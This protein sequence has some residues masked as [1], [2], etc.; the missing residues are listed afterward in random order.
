MNIVLV[1]SFILVILGLLVV[2]GLKIW[3]IWL[4]WIEMWKLRNKSK[5]RIVVIKLLAIFSI[6]IGGIVILATALLNIESIRT[7]E[8][9]KFLFITEKNK[10]NWIGIT[11]VLAII[12]L[13]VTSWDSRRKLKADLVSK[14]RIKWL[15]TVRPLVAEFTTKSTYY[16]FVLSSK[17]SKYDENLA[18]ADSKGT[19]ELNARRVELQLLYNKILL[20]TSND[21]SNDN[22]LLLEPL[23]IVKNELDVG[24]VGKR[25]DQMRKSKD[26][27]DKEN[28]ELNKKIENLVES[29]RIYFKKEW[30]KAKKGK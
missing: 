19:E 13:T 25:L 3:E 24:K 11:S 1:I 14:S 9:V 23:K 10:F 5:R 15:E 17:M 12:S 30:E 26:A 28:A 16:I 7:S 21:S 4:K 6:I 20:N 8:C 27:A 18:K 29:S 22:K 2:V